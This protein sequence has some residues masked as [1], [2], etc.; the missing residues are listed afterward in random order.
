MAIAEVVPDVILV[1]EVI[2]EAQVHLIVPSLL[3]ILGFDCFF[4]FDLGEHNLA[5]RVLIA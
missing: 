4:S 1:R 2:V 5:E 3:Q